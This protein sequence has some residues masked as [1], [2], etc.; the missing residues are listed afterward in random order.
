MASSS[1]AAYAASNAAFAAWSC[2]LL[3]NE[4]MAIAATYSLTAMEYAAMALAYDGYANRNFDCSISRQ[5]L[6]D[7]YVSETLMREVSG[8]RS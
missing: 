6:L 8:I 2:D 1:L 4:I 3:D 7:I 5:H